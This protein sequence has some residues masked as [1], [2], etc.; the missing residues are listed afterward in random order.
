MLPM[1]GLT[2]PLRWI[3][4]ARLAPRAVAGLLEMAAD[5]HAARRH[6]PSS[7]ASALVALSTSAA[8]R[9]AFALASHGVTVRVQ[10][11]I[12]SDRTSKGTAIAAGLLCTVA[13]F[14][15]LAVVLSS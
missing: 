6:A 9:C 10:R 3:P 4:Y 8:P 2:E 12:A 15:P 13:V 7:L 5:D 1:T 14:A 11:L